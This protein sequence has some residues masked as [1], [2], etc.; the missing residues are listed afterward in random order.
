MNISPRFSAQRDP[1]TGVRVVQVTSGKAANHHLYPSG[2]TATS[3]GR[4]VVHVSHESGAPNFCC[5]EIPTG[6][7]WRL[8]YR[9][10]I[11]PFSGA[12]TRDDMAVL[13]SAGEG[14]WAVT[15]PDGTETL[16]ASFAG[17]RVMDVGISPDGRFAVVTLRSG[18][19][20]RIVE[21]DLASCGCRDILVREGV[22]ARARYSP[23]GDRILYAGG[24]G[25]RVRVVNR[26]G[27]GDRLFYSQPAG[28]WVLNEAWLDSNT[29]IFVKFHDGLYEV[30]PPGG[31]RALFKGPVWHAAARGDG[32][33]VVCDSSSPDIGL[34]LMSADGTRWRT[35]CYPRSTNRGF[36][37]G[38]HLPTGDE[39]M[40]ASLL[41]GEAPVNDGKESEY[42]PE[43]T[44]PHPS[45]S[46]EG[47]S[48]YFTS[49]VSGVS[50]VYLAD[51]PAEWLGSMTG[52]AA[53]I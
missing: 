11:N 10:D 18:G 33:L 38:D 17:S 37:W 16:M 7:L 20:G 1:I 34:V 25:E 49:D 3:D 52:P 24:A 26:D 5:S 31:P 46:P 19:L 40:E 44:H 42:G 30:G 15:L 32:K 43:W 36:R 14:L 22:A 23:L 13:F 47:T 9:R 29:A 41:A 8:T 28:E 53:P 27:T 39:T 12:L 51:I 2:P 45:F 4:F 48:I 21:V 6:E 50:Q 35:L